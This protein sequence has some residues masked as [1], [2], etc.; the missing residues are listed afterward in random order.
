[1]I[2]RQWRQGEEHFCFPSVYQFFHPNEEDKSNSLKRKKLFT[3][4]IRDAKR[5][6]TGTTPKKKKNRKSVELKVVEDDEDDTVHEEDEE[7]EK[8][9]VLIKEDEK[10]FQTVILDDKTADNK[11][12]SVISDDVVDVQKNI[13]VSV[14]FHHRPNSEVESIVTIEA[15]NNDIKYIDEQ[16][17]TESVKTLTEESVPIRRKD[18]NRNIVNDFTTDTSEYD[19]SSIDDLDS[20]DYSDVVYREVRNEIMA[21]IRLET[22]LLNGIKQHIG[23]YRSIII[24]LWRCGHYL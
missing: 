1:M 18:Y 4:K 23:I 6:S 16:L 19:T 22:N 13:E 20:V 10:T 14:D 9:Q 3:F 15:N 2:F 24:F 8:D 12:S 5:K 21:I 11:H 7:E 17:E